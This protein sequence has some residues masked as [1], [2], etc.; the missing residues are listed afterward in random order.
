MK[1]QK[2]SIN[3]SL[4][5]GNNSCENN[6]LVLGNLNKNQRVGQGRGL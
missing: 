5:S 2:R 3:N 1:I 6:A 4:D